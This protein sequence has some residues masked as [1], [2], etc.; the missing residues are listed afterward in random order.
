[1][2]E[3]R[4]VSLFPFIRTGSV[5]Q[6][7][8]HPLEYTGNAGRHKA[9][10]SYGQIV[11]SAYKTIVLVEDGRVVNLIPTHLSGHTKSLRW[12]KGE[13]NAALL[14]FSYEGLLFSYEREQI[15]GPLFLKPKHTSLLFP[16]Q[17][18]HRSRRSIVCVSI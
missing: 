5:P 15:R 6:S 13:T 4:L 2:P 1:M 12:T 18:S 10:R 16:V 17:S 9:V 11:W 8:S 3:V 7:Q 14:L